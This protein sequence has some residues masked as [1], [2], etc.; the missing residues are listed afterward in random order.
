MLQLFLKKN[1]LST[2]PKVAVVIL[3][4]NGLPHIQRFLSSV[5]ASTYPNLDIVVADNASTDTSLEWVH[6]T[7]PNIK[8]L[9]GENNLGFAGG[10]NFFLRKIDADYYVLLNSDVLVSEKWIEPVID[11]M[12]MDPSIASCQPKILSVDHPDFFEY[13]GAAGGW[14]DILGYPFS[15]G[16][17]FETTEKDQGQYNDAVPV[18]WASGA[19]FFIRS[20]LF[21]EAGGF[22][23][24]FFAHQE[25]IDLCWRLQRKG[26]KIYVCPDAVVYHLGGGTLAVQS[27]RKVFLNYRN[28]LIMIARNSSLTALIWKLP[29][30]CLLDAISA[31]KLLLSGQPSHWLAILKAHIQFIIWMIK[32]TTQL[33]KGRDVNNL[34]GLYKG[35]VVWDY[36]VLG[37]RYF[38]QIVKRN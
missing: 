19:A 12:E 17:V 14:I 21:H 37:K 8:S 35:S 15:R 18:F 5:A 22:Y 2:F 33:G 11:L 32:N 20:K 6:N 38:S 4:W 30:R 24:P 29:L 10:Y 25:E 23:E 36:F 13:A 3:N 27:S 1:H 7:Y 28:N 16:R 31:W 9:K 26:Y 34:N